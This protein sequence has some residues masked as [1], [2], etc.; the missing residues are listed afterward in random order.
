MAIIPLDPDR[1][2]TGIV[3]I[4]G[5]LT[6][7]QTILSGLPSSVSAII[8]DPKQDGI[9]QMADALAGS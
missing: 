4:D 2:A 1:S 5:P 3:F 6:D 9:Q 8:L 7:L